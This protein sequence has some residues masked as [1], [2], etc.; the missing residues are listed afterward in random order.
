MEEVPT[1]SPEELPVRS[2]ER[3]EA[4]PAPAAVPLMTSEN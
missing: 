1:G 2:L 4:K 3:P